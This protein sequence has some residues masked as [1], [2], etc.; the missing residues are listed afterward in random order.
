VAIAALVLWISTVAIGTYLLATAARIGKTESA[1]A[2]NTE[3]AR[4]E[5]VPVSAGQ[6]GQAAQT[7][8]AAQA[9]T[10]GASPAASSSP[11]SGSD[12]GT[13]AVEA[14]EASVTP[15]AERLRVNKDDRYAPPS[16]KRERSE[17]LPGLK[18]LAE[19]AHPALALIGLAFWIGYVISR[20]RLML[21]IGLGILLGA[22]AAGLSWF[23]VNTRAA[24]RALADG[25]DEAS[26][27]DQASDTE[28][29]LKTAPLSFTPL[30]LILHTA[31][32]ALTLLFV[33]LIVARV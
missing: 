11:G 13:E 22:I 30:V 19:F 10:G 4:S 29:D 9:G 18:E 2:E 24:K 26:G 23:T 25:A 8:Q 16:L 7:G 6:A 21:A 12:S 32:A 5:A 14:V 3:P 27:A 31:G 28:E 17:P 20:D 33:A 15:L 1:P